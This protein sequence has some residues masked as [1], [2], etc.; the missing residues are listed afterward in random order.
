MTDSAPGSAAPQELG[1]AALFV[2]RPILAVVVNLLVIIA[3]LA[4]LAAVE[5]RELPN[6]SQPVITVTADYS[7]AAPS[8]ID[9][10]VTRV[11][12]DALA[13][14]EGLENISSQSTYGRSRLTLDLSS[15]T[16]I[17]ASDARELVAG[18]RRD[19]PDDVDEPIVRK[20]D[21]DADPVLRLALTGA[22]SLAELTTLAEDVVSD[23]LTTIEGVAEVEVNGGQDRIMRVTFS[24]IRLASHGISVA[25]V[26]EALA[27][28]NLDIPLGA[29]ETATQ[30]LVVRS[31]ASTTSVEAISDIRLNR[32]TVIGDI[33]FV[34]DTADDPDQIVRV[35]GQPAV[36][37]NVRRQSHANSLSIALAA[38]ELVAQLQR[39]L[40]EG[41]TLSITSDEGVFVE[42]AI[43]GVVTNIAMAVVI[44]VFVIFL[45]LRSLRAVIV[46]AVAVPI[47]L[48]GTLAAIW[49]TGFTVN[50]ITLLALVLA[51]GMVVDDAIVVL[52]NIIRKRREGLGAF[53]AAAV[54]TRE[55]FFAV[56]ST[57]AT[58]AAVFIPISFLPG[59][60]GGIFGEF[61]FVLAFAV[62]L[63]SFVALTLCPMLCAQLDPGAPKREPAPET[64]S[65]TE[66]A[67]RQSR[68]LL[69]F[70]RAVAGVIAWRLPVVVVALGFAVT[71]MLLYT[72]LPQELTPPEDRGMIFVQLR[73]PPSASLD[74]TGEQVA[75]IEAIVAPLTETGEVDAVLSIIGFGGKNTAFV[76]IRLAPWEERT[77]SQQEIAA[78]LQGPLRAVPG[79][80]I[81]LRSPNSL[82]IRG[83]GSGLQFAVVGNDYE[84]LED[85]TIALVERMGR[86]PAF[87]NPQL[88]YDINQPQLSLTIDRALAANLG[89]APRSVVETLYTMIEGDEVAEIFVDNQAIDIKLV[90]GG[91]PVNDQ[92]DLENT[93]VVASNGQFVPASTVAQITEAAAA[94]TLTREGRQRAVAAQANL[95]PGVDLGGAAD[96]LREIAEPILDDTGRLVFLGEA[97]TL[98]GGETGTLLVFAAALLIV[99][100]VLAAQ[101][102]SFVNALVILITVPC[103]LGTA[104]LA[105]W[106]T[107]GSLNYYSQIGL[108]LLVGIMAKNGILIVEFA[109]Q[110]R[111]QGRDVDSAIRDA[112]RIRLK[113][114]IMTMASTVCGSIPLVLASGA[115]AEARIAVGWVVVG[116]LGLATL[117]TLFLTPAVYRVIAPL[118]APPGAA[119]RK[120][121]EQLQLRFG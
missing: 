71:A 46:P 42:R 39:E 14:L 5:V 99:F 78:S 107:G 91:R 26:R 30:A 52:E 28:A 69:A 116:G 85:L 47:A 38:R 114:V 110:L 48:V 80:L 8:T 49:I 118:A 77:R 62:A 50:T 17:S 40:P 108:V 82:R 36:G 53:A 88:T 41:A 79:A 2:R 19:L 32:Q 34:Q 67:G 101:F 106:L 73:T 76:I 58:L 9:S 119:A 11:L 22:L 61:G 23:R 7:G 81:A 90:A 44:V 65:E 54:G 60:A 4:A 113:P 55:V 89:I 100:L 10:E 103:G 12:E 66:S 84:R 102:E 121:K 29:L 43:A 45:F 51:T 6:V 25:D 20:N 63:S 109:N 64:K 15:A 33:A 24:P 98:E 70:D 13:R 59:Q 87:I 37:L 72:Q 92:G 27:S 18:V 68:L 83:A 16:D 111:G 112:M 93:F 120:L 35:N 86:D 75:Q 57:T 56:I 96:R 115:G 95:G 31:E 1:S 105:I 97:A 104:L 94:A 74:Y 21:A 3:G 117:F